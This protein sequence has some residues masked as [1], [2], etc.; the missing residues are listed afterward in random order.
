VD[1]VRTDDTDGLLQAV[2]HL[3]DLGH[4]HI[5]HL[6]G[7]RTAGAA[8]RRRGYR[9]AM[10]DLGDG[11][12]V[13]LPGGLTEVQGAEGALAF[14]ALTGPFPSAVTAF[15]D[16][17]ALGFIDVVRRH[18]LRVPEDVSVVGFDNIE[19]SGYQHV[20]LT[21]VRQHVEGLGRSALERIA[22]RLDQGRS[23][24][25]EVVIAPDLVRRGSTAPPSVRTG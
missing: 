4:S 20:S 14:L 1:V 22:A 16:R 3:T 23:G 10:R 15:N 21:T 11:S 24:A 19:Q 9:L 2:R 6:D 8:D 7:G 12:R 25:R 13:E 18:G 17:C 5:A